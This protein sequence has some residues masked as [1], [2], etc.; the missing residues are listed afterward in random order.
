MCIRASYY[1][2]CRTSDGMRR[3]FRLPDVQSRVCMLRVFPTS[4]QFTVQASATPGYDPG[5]LHLLIHCRGEL[6][7]YGTLNPRTHKASFRWRD[8]PQG[9]LQIL[10]LDN[11]LQTLSERLLFHYDPR[12]EAPVMS[13]IHIFQLD[14]PA[15]VDPVLHLQRGHQ[16]RI[17]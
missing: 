5:V 15:V 11:R 6:C 14:R 7:Y 3:R 1:A 10:L 17:V 2:E 9:V 12:G 16:H 8:F 4:E 13:L